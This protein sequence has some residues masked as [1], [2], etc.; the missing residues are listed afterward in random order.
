MNVSIFTKLVI[1]LEE[2]FSFLKLRLQTEYHLHANYF[3]DI[4][5]IQ[6]K[7]LLFQLFTRGICVQS[8][9]QTEG[10]K[11]THLKLKIN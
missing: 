2:K 4:L 5:T 1:Y 8:P 7:Y 11:R 3:V 9:V 10:P 6:D